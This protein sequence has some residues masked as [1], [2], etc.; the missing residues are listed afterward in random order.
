[1]SNKI[2]KLAEKPAD[3]GI[4][5]RSIWLQNCSRAEGIPQCCGRVGGFFSA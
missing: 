2:I 5:K 1:M 4:K 3:P